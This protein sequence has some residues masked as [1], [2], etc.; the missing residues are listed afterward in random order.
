MVPSTLKYGV[1]VFELPECCHPRSPCCIKYGRSNG[2]Q[3]Y[4]CRR[5]GRRF[6]WGG[7][8]NRYSEEMRRRA[9]ELHRGGTSIRK[10]SRETGIPFSTVRRWIKDYENSRGYSTSSR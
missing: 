4:Y 6:V 8:W 1:A 5:M 3:T 7:R 9:L 2:K 10:I